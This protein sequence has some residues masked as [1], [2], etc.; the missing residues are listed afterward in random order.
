[1]K[2][3]INKMHAHEWSS[4][5]RGAFALIAM[6]AVLIAI[7][8]LTGCVSN[9]NGNGVQQKSSNATVS[10]FDDNVERFG[11]IWGSKKVIVDQETGIE[12]LY[13]SEGYK[14]GPCITVL[15]DTDGKPRVNPEWAA[16]HA[17]QAAD[18]RNDVQ[19]EQSARR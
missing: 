5:A 19:A 16:E 8:A 9:N 4:M 2:T 15:Y 13:I 6:I 7:V 1:M 17:S 11:R 3:T 14:S 18:A 12:Y 10:E